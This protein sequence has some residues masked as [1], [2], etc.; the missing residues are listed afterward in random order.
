[1]VQFSSLLIPKESLKETPSS[2][3]GIDSEVEICLRAYGCALI[4]KAGILLRLKAVTSASAAV[5]LHRF[6]FR[7][8]LAE[9]DIRFVA[10]ASLYLASKLQED[11]RRVKDVISV[12]TFIHWHESETPTDPPDVL[13]S[14]SEEFIKLRNTIHRVERYILRETGFLV[15]Q[16]LSHPHTHI[17]KF[18]DR[19]FAKVQSVQPEAIAQCAWGYIND[20]YRTTLCCEVEP[21]VVAAA[22]I[23]LAASDAN[24]PL[25]KELR[26]YELFDV[27]WETVMTAVDRIR[28]VYSAPAPTYV[29]VHGHKTR[30]LE[31]K[32][33]VENDNAKVDALQETETTEES[34]RV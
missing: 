4:Q 33:V 27:S 8:S 1:M 22:S 16:A 34:V 20:S 23:Y 5:L 24:V 3:D 14:D 6:Y 30:T 25:P 31:E 28:S 21:Q 18:V 29:R 12:F 15:S 32:S 17:L 19:L 13:S 2:K 10:A 26:W 7:R 9:F 11:A